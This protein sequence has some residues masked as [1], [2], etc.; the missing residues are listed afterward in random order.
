VLIAERPTDL[1][2]VRGDMAIDEKAIYSCGVT[3][4]LRAV[5]SQ[6]PM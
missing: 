2:D 1:L 4:S 6:T 5:D 3:A